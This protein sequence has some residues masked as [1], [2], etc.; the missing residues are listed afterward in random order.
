ML[1]NLAFTL[2]IFNAYIFIWSQPVSEK[3]DKAM[4]AFHQEQY[5]QS[6]RLFD[7]FFSEYKIIDELYS[8]AKYYAAE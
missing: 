8:T 7:D 6:Y 2:L 3:F 5:A 4:I 1:K